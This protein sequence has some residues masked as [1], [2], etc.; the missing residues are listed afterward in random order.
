MSP[1]QV[2]PKTGLGWPAAAT[3]RQGGHCHIHTGPGRQTDRQR[4]RH[5]RRERK[6]EELCR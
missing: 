4:G 2:K 3:D 6:F 5:T 1:P